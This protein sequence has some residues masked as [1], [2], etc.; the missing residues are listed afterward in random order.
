MDYIHTDIEI[1]NTPKFSNKPCGD[2]V[3]TIRDKY[4]TKIILADGLGSGIKANISATMVCARIKEMLKAGLSLEKTAFAVAKTMEDAVKDDLPYSVFEILE[5]FNDGHAR[6]LSYN[7]PNPL[8]INSLQSEIL[9]PREILIN[10]I[11]INEY[12]IRLDIREAIIIMSDGVTEA[13]LGNGLP[14]GWTSEGVK[15]YINSLIRARYQQNEFVYE[16]NAKAITLSSDKFND[17]I[18]VVSA[19]TRRGSIANIFSGPPK[20]KEKDQVFVR[21]FLEQKGQKIICGGTSAEIVSKY[22]CKQ[23]EKI[24]SSSSHI[25]PPSYS[26]SGIDLVTEGAMTLNQLYNIIDHELNELDY[27]NPVSE[28]LEYI[29]ISDKIIFY[30]GDSENEAKDDIRFIQLG[31]F[32][33]EKIIPMIAKKLESKGKLVLIERI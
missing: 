12:F 23:I 19:L 6:V 25:T 28:L 30:V 10:S 9:T 24:K 3:E 32:P 5:I 29:L 15:K 8:Y 26:M 1:S 16:I 22:T 33:R 4:S 18:T 31:I 11:K 7:M 2:V 27:S 21:K 20:D 13:G 14:K 17:D